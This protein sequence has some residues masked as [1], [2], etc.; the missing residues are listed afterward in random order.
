MAIVF[1][2][3][4]TYS[5]KEDDHD[6]DKDMNNPLITLLK[7][8][9]NQIYLRLDTVWIK[10]V[11][12]DEELHE[13]YIS[14]SDSAD[15]SVLFQTSPMVHDMTTYNV[16]TFWVSDVLKPTRAIVS[17]KAEDHSSNSAVQ[18]VKVTLDD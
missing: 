17:I 18:T 6:H 8:T 10:G 12:T 16:D 13:C 15:N 9:E 3:L 2:L 7:P 1:G 4:S 14:I 11:I 5:C